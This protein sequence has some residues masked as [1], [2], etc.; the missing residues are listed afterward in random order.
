VGL[1]ITAQSSMDQDKLVNQEKSR[2]K[3]YWLNG[4]CPRPSLLMEEKAL[5]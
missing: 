4:L 3:K 2:D 1:K 5:N